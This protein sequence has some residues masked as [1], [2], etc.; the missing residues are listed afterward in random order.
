MYK[1]SAAINTER[2][3]FGSAQPGYTEPQIEQWIEFMQDQNIQ[4]VCCL[5]PTD[6]L[7]KY[8]TDLL[9]TYRQTFEHRQVCWAPIKDFR[10]ANP[11]VL[12][13]QILPFLMIAKQKQ[14]KVVIHCSGGIGRTGHILA[15]WLVAE[16]GFSSQ[17]A[18]SAIKQSG[19]N[20]HEAV[21]AAPLKGRSPRKV[22]AEL[23]MLLNKCS[24]FQHELS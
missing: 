8:S 13:Y 3:V 19:R 15:A 7:S 11:D 22:A 5:L 1:F 23:D 6:Q 9:N 18:I 2:F 10:Y 14:E 4:R 16:H 21:V 12:I 17:S 20:P 24:N